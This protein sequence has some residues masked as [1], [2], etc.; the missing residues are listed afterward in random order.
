MKCDDP[1]SCLKPALLLSDKTA[2]REVFV[3]IQYVADEKECEVK[4]LMISVLTHAVISVFQI[5]FNIVIF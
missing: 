2:D 3:F 4:M 5:L 1:A